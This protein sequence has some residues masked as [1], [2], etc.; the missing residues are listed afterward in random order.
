MLY[1]RMECIN[2]IPMTSQTSS[3]HYRLLLDNEDKTEGGWKQDGSGMEAP[4]CLIEIVVADTDVKIM[5][6]K[7]WQAYK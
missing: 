5:M 2:R 1:L 3:Q 6:L 4:V 7:L